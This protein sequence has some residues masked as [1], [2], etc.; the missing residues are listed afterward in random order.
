MGYTTWEE[1]NQYHAGIAGA[2]VEVKLIRRKDGAIFTGIMTGCTPS[3]TREQIPRE[4]VGNV[5]PTEIITGR[6]NVTLSF[7]GYFDP[8]L[9]DSFLLNSIDW[10]NDDFDV[11][12]FINAGDFK[13]TII[14]V[15]FGW[16]PANQTTPQGGR[17]AL[18]F[19]MSG[20]ALQRLTGK[21]FSQRSGLM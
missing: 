7:N 9:N 14:D 5:N 11:H 10:G 18:T 13:E 4:V 2:I 8:S 19:D 20:P 21:Q 6:N 12:R 17:N 3:F 15:Y 1:S 16:K